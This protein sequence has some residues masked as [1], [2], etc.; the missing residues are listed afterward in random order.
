[1]HFESREVATDRFTELGL[2]ES[3]LE[4]LTEF[5]SSPRRSMA[6]PIELSAT[7]V[8]PLARSIGEWMGEFDEC[9]MLATD[10][11]IWP[12]SENW[13]LYEMLRSSQGGV[14][15]I[16]EAPLHVFGEGE[17]ALLA[18]FVHLALEFGWGFVLVPSPNI[19]VLNVSHDGWLKFISDTR[20]DDAIDDMVGLGFLDAPP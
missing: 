12:S 4:V 11:G 2:D 14:V 6:V 3:A 9:L 18:S 5:D 15:P 13:Q 19:C 17:R 16:N 10:Y 20:L 7:K 1:M 8:F